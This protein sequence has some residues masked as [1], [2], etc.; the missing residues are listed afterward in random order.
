MSRRKVS[1]TVYLLED[2]AAEL[3]R[4]SDLTRVPQ[5]VM[6]R[7]GVDH[8]LEKWR[9]IADERLTTTPTTEDR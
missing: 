7:D 1:T 4:L 8:A 9:R 3:Q 6:I 5:A 2:Q